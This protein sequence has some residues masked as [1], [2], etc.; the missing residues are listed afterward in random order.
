MHKAG[1]GRVISG[2][3]TASAALDTPLASADE[4]VAHEKLLVNDF[5]E[6]KMA[7]YFVVLTYSSSSYAI[8]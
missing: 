6:I 7:V 5:K 2:V 1:L 3:G 8:S 4:V